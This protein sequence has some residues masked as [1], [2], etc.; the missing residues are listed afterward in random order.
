MSFGFEQCYHVSGSNPQSQIAP[1]VQHIHE[2]QQMVKPERNTC[3]QV[4]TFR[5]SQHH[6]Q[7]GNSQSNVSSS[8]E[9]A[10]VFEYN[11]FNHCNTLS[12]GTKQLH[13]SHATS[14]D[15]LKKETEKNTKRKTAL[16]TNS[17]TD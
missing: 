2:W 4:H 6:A 12:Y 8:P 13:K 9:S 14:N 7:E 5:L 3:I 17:K 1:N 15:H 11:Q 10:C 16:T